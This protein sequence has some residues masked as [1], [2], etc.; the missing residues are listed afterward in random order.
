MFP[1]LPSALESEEGIE[2]DSG[3]EG[4]ETCVSGETSR[5][6]LS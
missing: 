2:N 4:R 3:L 5:Y 6:S 1:P